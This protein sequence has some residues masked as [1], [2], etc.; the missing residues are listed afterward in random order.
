MQD[1]NGCSECQRLWRDYLD[2]TMEHIR[3]DGKLK[4]AELE[5]KHASIDALTIEVE[6]AKKKRNVLR[7]AMRQH[8]ITAHGKAADATAMP[9][10]APAHCVMR[11]AM[12][13][14]IQRMLDRVDALANEQ[15]ELLNRLA[16]PRDLVSAAER[17][18][19]AARPLESLL[20]KYRLHVREHGC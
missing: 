12:A 19:A 2:A 5:R 17:F 4:M 6:H 9:Q 3:F 15:A 18:G 10:A 8:D 14:S 13:E 16:A 11:Q 1:E 20:E 7:E